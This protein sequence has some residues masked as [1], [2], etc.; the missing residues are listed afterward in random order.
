MGIHVGEVFIRENAAA[1]VARGAEPPEV[2]GLA[3]L[4]A[5]RLMSL[6]EGGQTLLTRAAFDSTRRAAVQS[7]TMDGRFV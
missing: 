6:A 2:E 7:G 3:R 4:V 5:S 1:E